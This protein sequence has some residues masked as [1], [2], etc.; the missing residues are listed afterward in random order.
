[1]TKWAGVVRLGGI[2]DDI[3]VSSIFPLLAEQGFR[4]EVFAS[5]PAIVVLENNPFIDKL[6][7]PDQDAMPK[8]TGADWQ[9]YFDV[10]AKEFDWFRNLSHSIETMVALQ[11]GQTQ[12]WW[13]QEYR[14]QI[15]GKNYLEHTHD[16]CGL[17]HR[18]APAFYPTEAER[19]KA[20]ETKRKLGERVIGWQIS[21]SRLDKTWPWTFMGVARLIRETGCPVIMFGNGGKEFAIA[22]ATQEQVQRENGH[23]KGLHVAISPEVP[24]GSDP[25]QPGAPGESV[26]LKSKPEPLWP[27]RRSLAQLQLCDVVIGPDTGP[28]WAVSMMPMP[29]IVLLSHASPVNITKNWVNTVSLHASPER[30]PCWPC[31]RLH[32]D[33]S[34]CV[35]NKDKLAAACMSDISVEDLV[36][37]V[38]QAI[39]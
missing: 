16:I 20:I 13:P 23:D 7:A 35:P 28:M 17:P 8:G 33:A 15:C 22:K 1:M 31:H 36:S 37:A 11:V 29:K 6:T 25:W 21:G 19:M 10:R 27:L 5:K 39:D 3:I 34:T 18:F 4:I 24:E 32:D 9:R 26:T 30:V 38:K 14:R 2:G 12:F